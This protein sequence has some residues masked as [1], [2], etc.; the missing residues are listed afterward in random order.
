MGDRSVY[1]STVSNWFLVSRATGKPVVC[2][3]VA[4]LVILE[5]LNKKFSLTRFGLGD[6]IDY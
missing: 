6:M 4:R 2:T 3:G 1:F 5:F